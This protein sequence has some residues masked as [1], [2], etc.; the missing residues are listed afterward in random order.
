[1]PV[2]RI[3][4]PPESHGVGSGSSDACTQRIGAPAPSRPATRSSPISSTRPWTVSIAPGP[5]VAAPAWALRGQPKCGR[6]DHLVADDLLPRFGQHRAQDAVDLLEL[7]RVGD[8]WRAE[9]DDRVAAVVGAADQ[10]ML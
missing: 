9:L 8:Q 1:M 3:S 2:V 10:A 4:S 7:G 6:C 5:L